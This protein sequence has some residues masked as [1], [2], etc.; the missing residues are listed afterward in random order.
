MNLLH[1]SALVIAGAL[2]P[3]VAQAA[4]NDGLVARYDFSG[5]AMDSSGYGNDGTVVGASL[6]SDRFGNP[7]SA[8]AF[9]GIDNYIQIPESSAFDSPA[10]SI[11][12]WFRATAYPDQAGMLIS[13]GQN[14]FEIHT[15]SEVTGPTGMKFLPRFVAFGVPTDWSSPTDSYSIGNWTHVTGIYDPGNAIQFY[16]DGVAVPLI[17]PI[18]T[19]SAPDNLVDARI[20]MR[21]D[22]TLAFQGAIDDVRI[23]DRVLTADEVGQLFSSAPEASSVFVWSLLC[24]IMGVGWWRRRRSA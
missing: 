22:N 9:N 10:F 6:T 15:G 8:Y 2:F 24:L 1:R 14:N 11:S 19:P 21:T 18:A 16:I 5:N 23:Y 4:L 12:L 17:G 7:D 20:G 13:K 3:C